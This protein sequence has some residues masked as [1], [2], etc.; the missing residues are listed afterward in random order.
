MTTL[1][2]VAPLPLWELLIHLSGGRCQC[3][4]Q[5][6]SKHAAGQGRCEHENGGYLSKHAGPIRLLVAPKDPYEL[7]R[8]AH[9]QARLSAC[10]L[11]AWCPPCHDNART[12]VQ[13]EHR[14]ALAELHTSDALF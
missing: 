2:S 9:E 13:R 5:C 11:A 3:T 10:D 8:P 1:P 14:K 6:G 12:R 4:G 7:I